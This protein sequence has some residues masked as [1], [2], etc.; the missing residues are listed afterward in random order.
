MRITVF[1]PTYNR[2]Y[3]IENLYRS[4]QRQNFRD[5]EW[6]VIDDGSSDNTGQLF[7]MFI[8]E[9][10]DF[11]IKYYK[12]KN[13]GKHRAINKGLELAEGEL[14]YIVDSDDFL[15]DNALHIIN[16]VENSIP[17]SDKNKFGGVCGIK[18]FLNNHPIGTSFE[19][20]YLD[21]TQLERIKYKVF[22][23]KGEVFYTAL[24]KKYPFPQFEGENFIT[25][26]VVWDKIAFDGYKLRFFNET[27]MYCEY[28]SDGLS[29][30]SHN[31]FLNNPKGSG[32]YIHQCDK[33]GKISRINK[34]NIYLQYYY[35]FRNKLSFYD[36][37]KNLKM[38][39][40]IFWLRILGL[41]IFYKLYD[42]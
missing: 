24:L 20:K 14:F 6:I 37:S 1:T 10:N 27:I 42:K 11:I 12:T 41:K 32:L 15:P 19:G 8:A 38:N 18:S 2:G 31:L 21:I 9:K 22:G 30:Q 16:E 39:V 3:I 17:F 25:E 28:R 29:A 13:G 34:W 36:I 35:A 33:F 40:L 5:F 4:L 23:D 7:E 26:C